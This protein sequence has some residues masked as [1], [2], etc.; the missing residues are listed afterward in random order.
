MA[1]FF[2]LLGAS[3]VWIIVLARHKVILKARIEE[4][5]LLL[6]SGFLEWLSVALC[7]LQLLPYPVRNLLPRSL[8]VLQQARDIS[9][10]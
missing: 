7:A 10:A 4:L 3:P 8:E 9:L 5:D 2:L 6:D 1:D